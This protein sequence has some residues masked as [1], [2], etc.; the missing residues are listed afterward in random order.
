MLPVTYLLSVFR[1]CPSVYF[2]GCSLVRSV[3]SIMPCLSVSLVYMY[4][5]LLISVY[6]CSVLCVVLCYC[7]L[8]VF[9]LTYCVLSGSLFVTRSVQYTIAHPVLFLSPSASLLAQPG[10]CRRVFFFCQYW[11]SVAHLFALTVTG[12]FSRLQGCR[13]LALTVLVSCSPFSAGSLA[14]PISTCP[15]FALGC[16]ALFRTL[17]TLTLRVS[18][19]FSSTFSVLNLRMLFFSSFSLRRPVLFPPTARVFTP[20]AR[21]LPSPS[22]RPVLLCLP[23]KTA[24]F[25]LTRPFLFSSSSSFFDSF[26]LG[27][28]CDPGFSA[29]RFFPS[30]LSRVY[31]P[32]LRL[33]CDTSGSSA[34]SFWAC[35][36]SSGFCLDP[37]FSLPAALHHPRSLQELLPPPGLPSASL[38]QAKQ[39][40]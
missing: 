3:S 15:L 8:F 7:T 10:L 39:T 30:T 22:S 38:V 26:V 11:P 32:F 9:V 18:R 29:T 19:S 40:T 24:G 13:S 33:P 2:A 21:V 20:T 16:S 28:F 37:S 25:F 1:G 17:C 27:F 14:L 35:R 12:R 4:I 34:R 36:A 6:I 31:R 5:C 23:R